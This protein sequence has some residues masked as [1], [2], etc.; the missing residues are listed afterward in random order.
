MKEKQG[1][2]SMVIL[3]LGIGFLFWISWWSERTE[4]A[5]AFWI[6]FQERQ[7]FEQEQ[8]NSTEEMFY[9]E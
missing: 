8:R 7:R 5:D 2:Y 9:I 3:F 6:D 1:E 4:D